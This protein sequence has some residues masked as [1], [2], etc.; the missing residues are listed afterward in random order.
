M[1]KAFLAAA[2]VLLCLAAT[3]GA[4][5][6][7]DPEAEREA[8]GELAREGVET[9]LRALEALVDMIPQYEMPELTEEGDIIIRRKRPDDVPRGEPEIEETRT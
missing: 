2:T 9:L 6:A 5:P 7:A 4:A 8:P 3:P 1:T